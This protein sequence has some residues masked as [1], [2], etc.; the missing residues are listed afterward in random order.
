MAFDELGERLREREDDAVGQLEACLLAQRVHL[1]DQVVDTALEAQL[2]VEP[3]VEGDGQAVR[4]GDR[5]ALAAAALDQH[6]AR[7]ELVARGAEPA[8]AELLEIAGGERLLHRAELAT[9]SRA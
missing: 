1:S 4:R 8:L 9:E 3:R 6:V 7:V 5:E 2:V